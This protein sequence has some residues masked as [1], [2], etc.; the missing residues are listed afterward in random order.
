MASE[1]R[2]AGILNMVWEINCSERRPDVSYAVE[3][4]RE[5][6]EHQRGVF[7]KGISLFDYL[8]KGD[9]GGLT[10]TLS[11]ETALKH[12]QS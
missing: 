6:N 3:D 12:L 5:G 4:Q 2:E 9:I 11:Y 7:S 10:E 1:R 8:K